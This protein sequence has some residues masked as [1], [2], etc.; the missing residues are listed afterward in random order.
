MKALRLFM[1]VLC[2]LYGYAYS[3]VVYTCRVCTNVWSSLRTIDVYDFLFFHNLAMYK[4][5]ACTVV[6]TT[7]K[8][9]EPKI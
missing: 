5:S 1:N 2:Y 6:H 9:I 8:G 3:S 7:G 4:N